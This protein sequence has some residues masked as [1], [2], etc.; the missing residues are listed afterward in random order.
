MVILLETR[1]WWIIYWQTF[2]PYCIHFIHLTNISLR[3]IWRVEIDLPKSPK[4]SPTTILYRMWLLPM[5]GM[6]SSKCYKVIVLIRLV[7]VPI[8][9]G[10]IVFT[11]IMEPSCHKKFIRIH[12]LNLMQHYKPL[13]Q[14]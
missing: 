9:L 1:F 13:Y 4:F 5:M 6:Q 7:Y 10:C 2:V 8:V 14:L 12:A 3:I 11:K